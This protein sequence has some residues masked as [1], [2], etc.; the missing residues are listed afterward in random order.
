MDQING[1]HGVA[2]HCVL[3]T[4]E[5]NCSLNI[6][7]TLSVFCRLCLMACW[8]DSLLTWADVNHNVIGSWLRSLSLWVTGHLALIDQRDKS[9]F[10]PRKSLYC[11][12]PSVTSCFSLLFW[13]CRH[14]RR[15]SERLTWRHAAADRHTW[16]LSH[17]TVP[18]GGGATTRGRAL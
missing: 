2:S 6:S 4:L 17:N 11:V 16:I 18:R 5:L 9:V 12:F 1:G 15:P 8:T 13:V 7:K 3:D 10:L 14:G